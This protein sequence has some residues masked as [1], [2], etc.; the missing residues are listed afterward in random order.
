MNKNI[1]CKILLGLLL[2]LAPFAYS[3]N[4]AI[5]GSATAPVNSA[6]LDLSANTTGGFLLPY[7]TTAQ[8]NAIASPV[9]NSLLV[10]N[11]DNNC[12]EGYFV[13][14]APVC[15][16]WQQ[17]YCPCS[18][19]PSVP[20]VTGTTSLCA[21]AV[22]TYT[23]ATS[24]NG[25]TSYTWTL[26]SGGTFSNGTTTI[27][28]ASLTQPVTWGSPGSTTTYTV[29][30]Q[31]TNACGTT[32]TTGTLA[33]IVNAAL[34]APTGTGPATIGL[35]SSDTYSVPAVSGTTY[36]W[37]VPSQIG[38]ITSGAGTNS[39]TI[40]ASG[41]VET[42]YSI[43]IQE[44]GPCNTVSTNYAVSTANCPTAMSGTPANSTGCT[45]AECGVVN[46]TYTVSAA[47]GAIGG[48]SYTWDVQAGG[49]WANASTTSA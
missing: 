3:Q 33:V 39:I 7:V 37:T 31:G 27:T 25:A 17:L 19:S 28:G 9:P 21:A 23:V 30:V 40:T 41:A 29:S 45:S 36:T 12:I 2:L 20:V 24:P 47:T 22:A 34:A 15:N 8:M 42:T 4:V 49:L 6:V 44:V 35:N 18:G 16:C 38:T 46:Y 5:N 1:L 11:S 26:S 10:Y 13:G 32:A 48:T 14:S 43:T